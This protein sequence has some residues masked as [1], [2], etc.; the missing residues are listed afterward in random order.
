MIISITIIIIIIMI[1]IMIMMIINIFIYEIIYIYDYIYDY[2]PQNLTFA[3]DYIIY[4][5]SPTIIPH[6]SS[7]VLTAL[8][9][10]TVH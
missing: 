8:Q 5:N 6:V 9:G 4:L 7:A 1:M 2:H 10:W 3:H